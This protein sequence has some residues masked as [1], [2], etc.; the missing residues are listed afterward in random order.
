MDDGRN[1]RWAEDGV[2]R[3]DGEERCVRENGR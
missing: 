3:T 2:R 1:V